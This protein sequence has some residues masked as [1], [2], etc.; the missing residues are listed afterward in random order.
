VRKAAPDL[1]QR[2]LEARDWIRESGRFFL[3]FALGL[4]LLHLSRIPATDYRPLVVI[5]P[6]GTFRYSLFGDIF[7]F[8]VL[9]RYAPH[10]PTPAFALFCRAGAVFYLLHGAASLGDGL[11][12]FGTPALLDAAALWYPPL[13]ALFVLHRLSSLAGRIFT[14][15]GFLFAVAGS[16]TLLSLNLY[17]LFYALQAQ[18]GFRFLL[19]REIFATGSSLGRL[20]FTTGLLQ[21][22]LFLFLRLRQERLIPGYAK[23]EQRVYLDRSR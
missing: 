6:W 9:R 12:L 3:T 1:L 8:I 5:L 22:L 19:S 18:P 14:A 10:T 17:G 15:G 23:M 20:W 7:L 2:Y 11:G 13:L 16:L 4:G 21:V